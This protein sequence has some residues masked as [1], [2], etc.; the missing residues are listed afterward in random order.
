MWDNLLSLDRRRKVLLLLLL[1]AAL[2]ARLA[3]Y[4]YCAA[5][6]D[7]ALI[8]LRYARNLAHGLGFVYNPGERVLGATTPLWIL[9]NAAYMRLLGEGTVFIFQ[10]I[11]SLA[12]DLLCLVL[13]A[14][15]LLEAGFRYAVVWASL[16][17]VALFWPFVLNTS[18][19]MEMSFFSALFLLSLRAFQRDQAITA[20]LLAGL[21]AV[22]RPEGF[23]WA[24]LILLVSV[25]RD[26]RLPWRPGLAFL[27]VALPWI[28]FAQFYFG[29]LI[30]Q[31]AVA[32]APSTYHHVW[33]TLATGLWA[34]PATVLDLIYAR[35]VATLPRFNSA[36][37]QWT[38]HACLLVCILSGL[39]VAV[40]RKGAREMALMVLVLV[41]FYSLAA[42]GAAG[43]YGIPFSQL[44]YP[45]AMI[46]VWQLLSAFSPLL[47]RR[48]DH[49]AALW[50][51]VSCLVA[52]VLFAVLVE[53]AR[54]KKVT[55]QYEVM[56]RDLGL[57][58]SRATP[59]T[60]MIMLEPIGYI[61][62]Y[63][64]RY[65]YDLAGL[66][67]PSI[68]ELRKH[69]PDDWY[70]RAIVTYRPDYL[71]LRDFETEANRGFIDQKPFFHSPSDRET[72]NRLYAKKWFF[73]GVTVH[74]STNPALVVF[75][76]TSP[77]SLSSRLP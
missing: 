55:N 72:F 5:P 17:P 74:G 27:V 31:S 76:R 9:L 48:A 71:V 32:K 36:A 52:L 56:R 12:C 60:S 3:V 43:W 45:I 26:R 33:Q 22:C 35:P 59:P 24:G 75:E 8:S 44:F 11:V 42:G 21:L 1:A 19:G 38:L 14:A 68:T 28:A 53:R 61:G 65:V 30:P 67:S 57:T 41:T 51:A 29:S 54:N 39:A 15:I 25:L 2:A 63:S 16:L 47:W 18:C 40:R 70:F 58:L 77:P 46:G 50:T 49:T 73:S 64:Q 37:V 62:Y 66:V 20:F 4:L 6:I 13:L 23:L 69:Y 10:F 34:V 7:D